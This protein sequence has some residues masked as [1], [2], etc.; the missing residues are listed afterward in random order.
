MISWP[1]LC[2]EI[3][4]YPGFPSTRPERVLRLLYAGGG[5]PRQA[6]KSASRTN[7][8]NATATYG[9]ALPASAEGTPDNNKK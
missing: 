8:K 2:G 9:T 7:N 5:G 3:F 4:L 6:A 1:R